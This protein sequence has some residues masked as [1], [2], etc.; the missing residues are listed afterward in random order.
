M[1]ENKEKNNFWATLPG[2]L[3][4]LAALITAMGGIYA[5]Y[6][7]A[8]SP[9]KDVV[10]SS[11]AESNPQPSTFGNPVSSSPSDNSAPP[12]SSP[13]LLPTSASTASFLLKTECQSSTPGSSLDRILKEP[14]NGKVSINREVSPLLAVMYDW[15]ADNGYA[16]NI[17]SKRPLEFV[18]NLNSSYKKLDLV[19][20]I[21]DDHPLASPENELMFTVFADGKQIGSREI[22]AGSK[23][24]WSVDVAS[25][26]DVALRVECTV[27]SCPYLGF[28]EMM[29]K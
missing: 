11:P 29:L 1:S 2:I 4:G 20:G 28:T 24:E 8:Q 25:I 15:I 10:S 23:Q 5:I 13:T 9:P 14:D 26:N 7:G 19:F 21:A 6:R 18:C 16:R 12:S 27:K 17:Y 3:T 22:V